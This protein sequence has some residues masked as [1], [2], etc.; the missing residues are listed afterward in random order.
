MGYT[1]PNLFSIQEIAPATQTLSNVPVS[2]QKIDEPG[3]CRKTSR[4]FSK[5]KYSVSTLSRTFE[6]RCTYTQFDNNS[7]NIRTGPFD[8][9]H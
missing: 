4:Y 9:S 8:A 5:Y 3:V 6:R 7:N 2:E 1:F